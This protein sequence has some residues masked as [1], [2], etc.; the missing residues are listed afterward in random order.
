[1]AI[2]Q[3]ADRV[4]RSRKFFRELLTSPGV[5]DDTVAMRQVLVAVDP[6]CTPRPGTSVV[7][8]TTA[9]HP[10]L[11][12][13]TPVRAGLALAPGHVRRVA[14]RRVTPASLHEE[15]AHR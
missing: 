10:P 14:S 2:D 3:L 7:G 12:G 9:G 1:I 4:S 8:D 13:T 11:R 5:T 15:E 6:G